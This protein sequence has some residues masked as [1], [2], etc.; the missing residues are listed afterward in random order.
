VCSVAADWKEGGL[1]R[2]GEE[3]AGGSVTE[4]GRRGGLGVRSHPCSATSDESQR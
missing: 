3:A 4:H 1:V 2:R